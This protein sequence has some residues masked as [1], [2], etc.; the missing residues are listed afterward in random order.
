MFVIYEKEDTLLNFYPFSLSH[1]LWDLRVGI[2][3]I[4][5]LWERYLGE[6]V[7]VYT[8]RSY[9][10]EYVE[11]TQE[12][13]FRKPQSGDIVIYSNYL[14]QRE[15]ANKVKKLKEGEAITD[16]D[17]EII[18]YGSSYDTERYF[19]YYLREKVDIKKLNYLF[20]VIDLI[21]E[22]INTEFSLI[23]SNEAPLIIES[24]SV[25]LL[26]KDRMRFGKS[27]KIA[28]FVVI[29]ATQGCVFI[30]DNVEIL[31]F[32]YI[33]GPVYIGRDSL[34]KPNSKLC[35]GVSIGK[36]S[37]VAGE[38]EESIVLGYSNKQHDG[39]LGHSF[40]GEWVNLGALT[41]N[42]DLKNN[43]SNIK[44]RVK[45]KVIETNK[46]FL[47]VFI[48]D[49]SKSGIITMFNTGTVMGFSSNVFNG[50]FQRKFIPSFQWGESD[51]Y[52]LEKAINTATVVMGRRSVKF[53]Q[54]HK[55]LFEY[56]F[57]LRL[58]DGL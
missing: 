10:R 50:G 46:R 27:V 13:S 11:N 47:G 39:F 36:V 44:I 48:G 40:I 54:A 53:T 14:P 57:E 21:G 7:Y 30:D 15:L 6:K 16:I 34:V 45:D 2:F 41:T 49:H 58:K 20:N 9:I 29:D 56:I 35:N 3:T 31:P 55:K 43:Y 8:E 51:M 52:H 18:A 12:V 22:R 33:K 25:K 28:P 1:P 26:G 42:S 32:S 19:V 23:D 37:K 38:I 5:E 24:D 4:K 17:G